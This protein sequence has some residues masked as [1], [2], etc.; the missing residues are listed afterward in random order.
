[1]TPKQA[2]RLR[3][4]ITA[5]RRALAAEKRRFGGYDDSRGLR[6]F[7]TRYYVQLGDFAGG[8]T[9][10]RWFAKCFPDDAGFADFLLEWTIILFQ[11]GQHAAAA[12]KALETH[13][14]D[15]HLVERFLEQPGTPREPW[16]TA[17]PAA[18]T[19]ARYFEAL[20]R[21][22]ALLGFT[23]WLTALTETEA[24]RLGARRFV[25]LNRQLH[26]EHDVEKRHALV[27]QLYTP[28]RNTPPQAPA[29]PK[30]LRATDHDDSAKDRVS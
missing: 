11:N 10:V 5:I 22:T 20:G 18:D 7:P 13:C 25:D 1:M 24:F 8:R 15:I 28:A 21:S 16:E 23:T 17:L 4:Q 19:E 3:Q 27:R 9:Y 30:A 12:E 14:A 2:D 29:A 26:G 6:Y